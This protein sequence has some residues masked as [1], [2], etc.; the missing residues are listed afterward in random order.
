MAPFDEV[1]DRVFR[2]RYEMLDSNVGVIL[3]E[4]GVVVIDTR[5]SHAQADEIRSELATITSDPV[6][7]VVNTHYHWDHV[8]GNARFRH[9]PIWGHVRCREFLEVEGEAMRESVLGSVAE[10][11]HAAIRGVHIVPPDHTFSAVADIDLGDR[12]VRLSYR[13]RGHTDSDVVV[14]VD[15]ADVTFVGDLVE[16][17]APPQ[18][19]SAFPQDWPATLEA[20]EYDLTSI[21]VPGHGD[22]VDPAFVSTQRKQVAAVAELVAGHPADRDEPPVGPFPEPIMAQALQRYRETTRGS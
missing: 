13:G 19:G 17:G 8:W 15:G 16:E 10:E 14:Q 12:R 21:V 6:V 1:G 22:V 7:A 2:R 3:S 20:V 18:Y 4:A 11:Y 9:A 5:A